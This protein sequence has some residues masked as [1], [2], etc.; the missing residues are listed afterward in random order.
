MKSKML[1][2][3]WYERSLFVTLLRERTMNHPP[4]RC[5]RGDPERCHERTQRGGG[6]ISVM[7][8]SIINTFQL[9]YFHEI[10]MS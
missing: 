5:N 7:L 2:Q 9:S 4:T 10:E 1:K 6:V 3:R 8:S